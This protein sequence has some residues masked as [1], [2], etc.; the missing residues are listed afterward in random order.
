MATAHAAEKLLAG[1]IVAL[2]LLGNKCWK[3][4]LPDLE[5]LKWT[6]L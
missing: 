2:Y 5:L 6:A 3:P 4:V 1:K